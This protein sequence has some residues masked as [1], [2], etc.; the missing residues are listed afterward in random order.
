M[1]DRQGILLDDD[2]TL[3]GGTA[4]QAVRAYEVAFGFYRV[5]VE[6][7]SKGPPFLLQFYSRR[8]IL[9]VACRI[10]RVMKSGC[11]MVFYLHIEPSIFLALSK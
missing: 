10:I 4:L 2:V 6:V 7:A 1:S 5:I 8:N 3:I 11:P 9:S